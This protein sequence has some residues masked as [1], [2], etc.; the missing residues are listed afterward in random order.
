MLE[1]EIHSLLP[2]VEQASL[3]TEAGVASKKNTLKI[4]AVDKNEFEN[5][6]S[7]SSAKK[8]FLKKGTNS[9]RQKQRHAELA[10]ALVDPSPKQST[11]P[12]ALHANS[13]S[14]SPI[15]PVRPLSA[16][17]SPHRTRSSSREHERSLPQP[18][19]SPAVAL[20]KPPPDPY[21]AHAHPRL[22][23]LLPELCFDRSAG[24]AHRLVS[25]WLDEGR[26][27]TTRSKSMRLVCLCEMHIARPQGPSSSPMILWHRC[28]HQGFPVASSK[29]RSSCSLSV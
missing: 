22:T 5:S 4:T 17:K 2:T 26:V 1:T 24:A 16:S 9:L 8:A 28:S 15:S 20:S 12:V 14:L 23:L 3:Q 13:S 27:P 18:T 10:I 21:P 25:S 29:G 6:T 7:S 11:Q 19:R